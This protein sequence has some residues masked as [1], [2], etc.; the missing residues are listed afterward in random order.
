MRRIVPVLALCALVLAAAGTSAQFQTYTAWAIDSSQGGFGIWH[1]LGSL[2]TGTA[3]EA[4]WQQLFLAP[5]LPPVR[6]L[7]DGIELAPHVSTTVPYTSVIFSAG[8]TSVTSLSRTFATNLP[9]PVTVHGFQSQS[10]AWPSTGQWYRFT[11]Q[12]PLVYDGQSH[13]IIEVQKI[14]DRVTNPGLGTMSHLNQYP[15]RNDLPWPI[16][17]TGSVG[18][19]AATAPQ[20]GTIYNGGPL[21]MR[22]YWTGARTLTI[23]S[24]WSS[25]RQ[26]YHLGS[27]VNLT[28][29]GPAG[30]VF[31]VGFDVALRSSPLVI[32]GIQGAWWLQ[33][34]FNLLGMGIINAQNEGKLSLPVPNAATLVG[35]QVYFQAGTVIGNSV[36]FTNVVDFIVS[37]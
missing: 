8:H 11:F 25:G 14:I 30:E 4:R 18:S 29:R 20:A 32:P 26:P 28:T 2:S 13:L 15:R 10:I 34:T 23:G 7:L 9:V 12:A 22:L 27:T 17:S 37:S 3:D 16:W 6:A 21:L 1:P 36:F 19:G 24:T 31:L 5:Y 33:G 35:T